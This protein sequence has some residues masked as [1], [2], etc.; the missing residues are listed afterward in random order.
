MR[1]A[2]KSARRFLEAP[3]WAG[4]VLEPSAALKNATTDEL[5]DQYIKNSAFSTSH[6]V[7]TAAMSKK[8]APYGVVDPDLLVKGV[9]GL[10][11]VDASVMVSA[12]IVLSTSSK[13]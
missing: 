4:Y 12:L 10:R 3:T 11:I 5:L 9:T 8:N 6:P 7:G 2:I 13:C 1:E